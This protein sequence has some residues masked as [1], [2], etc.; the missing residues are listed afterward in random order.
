MRRDPVPA[1]YRIYQ[2]LRERIGAGQYPV[3]TRLPTD[4]EIMAE[5]GVSRHTARSAVEELVTRQL[6]RRFPGRGTF[7]L[8]SNP[9]KPDWSARAL[10]DLQILDPEARFV[11]H[12]IGMLEPG[13]APVA[14]AMLR[15]EADQPVFRIAWSRV[16]PEGPIAYCAAHV[17]G[18]LARRLPPDLGTLLQ[19][20]RTIPLIE[21]HCGVQAFRV[22][23]VSSAVAA[24]AEMAARL[25]MAPG[26]PVLL[27]QR[28]YFD[29]E[30]TPIYYSDLFV[31][32]D[33]FQPRIELFRFRQQVGLART[34]PAD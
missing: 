20:S 14:A 21:K 1:Y 31:R 5:F 7:I 22:R 12:G 27:L 2:V 13:A 10:E 28:T 16:R 25:E 30:G 34:R 9:A 6:V 11:L 19:T 32:S 8:E 29:V 26:T 3:G 15:L 23:Q 33:R 17:P 18:A 4:H 24:D